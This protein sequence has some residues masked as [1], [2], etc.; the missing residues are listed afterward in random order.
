MG[1]L[2]TIKDGQWMGVHVTLSVSPVA[3]KKGFNSSGGGEWVAP[4]EDP[5][6]IDLLR[7]GQLAPMGCVGWPHPD[8]YGVHQ[9]LDAIQSRHK[10]L[11]FWALGPSPCHI[12]WC[13]S[14]LPK[15]EANYNQWTFEVQS[16]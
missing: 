2:E 8:S 9:F 13:R 4:R 14:P 16:L 3:M 7:W 15:R 1:S 12:Q 10:I 6:W 5:E 11:A